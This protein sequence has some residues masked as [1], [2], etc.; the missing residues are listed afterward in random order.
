[1]LLILAISLGVGSMTG[2][3]GNLPWLIVLSAA[4]LV[5]ATVSAIAHAASPL[6]TIAFAMATVAGFQAA[7]ILT[8]V[9]RENVTGWLEQRGLSRPSR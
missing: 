8:A 7:A 2:A 3:A 1:M 6:A 5:A 4:V 9:A